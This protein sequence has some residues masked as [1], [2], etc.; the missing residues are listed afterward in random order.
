MSMYIFHS[1]Y[2]FAFSRPS[3]TRQIRGGNQGLL[4]CGKGTTYEGGMREPAIAWMPGK[5]TPG[6]TMEVHVAK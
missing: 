6:R 5:V 2:L 4:K 1:I 3:L